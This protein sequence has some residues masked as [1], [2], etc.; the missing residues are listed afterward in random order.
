[1]LASYHALKAEVQMYFTQP[2]PC[3]SPQMLSLSLQKLRGLRL[4]QSLPLAISASCVRK[5]PAS[6]YM[7]QNTL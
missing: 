2:I 5:N 7:E 4:A 3:F 6:H 1:M